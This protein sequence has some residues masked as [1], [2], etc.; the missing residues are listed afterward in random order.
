MTPGK[1]FNLSP[2]YPILGLLAQQPAHGYELH[3]RLE[4][5]LGQIWRVSLS[6]VY[7]I[8]NRLENR[9]LIYGKTEPQ[10]R[11]P[12]RRLFH[13]TDS[14]RAHFEAWLMAP[15][16]SSVKAVRVDFLTRLYFARQKDARLTVEL[17]A[18]QTVV[19]R[20]GLERLQAERQAAP[21]PGTINLLGLDLRIRQLDSVLS[22]LENIAQRLEDPENN[23]VNAIL[24]AD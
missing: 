10:E 23:I 11:L 16:G 1:F 13:L 9:G 3:Q 19:I 21:E 22:W 15:C 8:L 2:E 5:E 24:I 20:Q 12:D 17:V 7:N 18:R 14:G 6:Q 4:S